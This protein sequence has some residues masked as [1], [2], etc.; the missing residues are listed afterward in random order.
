MLN[1][2][3]P[4]FWLHSARLAGGGGH[5]TTAF[6]KV[7]RAFSERFNRRDGFSSNPG[8]GY[9]PSRSGP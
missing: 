1:K 3:G 5:V 7:G 9:Q 2:Q 8:G 4:S 6:F